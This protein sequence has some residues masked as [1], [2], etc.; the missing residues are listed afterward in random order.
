[1]SG[2]SNNTKEFEAILGDIK[3][4][5]RATKQISVKA[6]IVILCASADNK[7][8]KLL[9]TEKA[10]LKNKYGLDEAFNNLNEIDNKHNKLNEYNPRAPNKNH[11]GACIA[12]IW[13]PFSACILFNHQNT[14]KRH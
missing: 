7:K 2:E 9:D 14:K 12:V 4:N 13:Q 11:T 10:V 8:I 3:N 1:M 6:V 5:G